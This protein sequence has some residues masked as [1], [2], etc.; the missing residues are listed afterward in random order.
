MTEDIKEAVWRKATPFNAN[1]RTDECGALVKWE[2]Y[3]NRESINGWELDHITPISEGGKDIVSNLR[4]L[5]WKNNASRQAGRLNKT[6]PAVK[7]FKKDDVKG[8]WRN[9]ALN[10]VDG[11]YYYM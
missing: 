2:D 4:V 6:K 10:S 11:K 3:G 9:A 1:W 8:T 5:H 7:A